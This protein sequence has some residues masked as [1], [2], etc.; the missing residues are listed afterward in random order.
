MSTR[1]TNSHIKLF[2]L[3]PCKQND[4]IMGCDDCH[5]SRLKIKVDI[6]TKMDVVTV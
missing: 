5:N 1:S 4:P 6:W 3:H 2:L